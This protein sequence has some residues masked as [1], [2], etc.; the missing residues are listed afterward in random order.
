VVEV[1]RHFEFESFLNSLEPKVRTIVK[2][3][4]V[5]MFKT[6]QWHALCKKTSL[7]GM[8]AAG[9][10]QACTKGKPGL[11][12]DLEVQDNNKSTDDLNSYWLQ[13]LQTKLNLSESMNAVD[14]VYCPVFNTSAL[15]VRQARKQGDA[16]ATRAAQKK[17]RQEQ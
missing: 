13:V 12:S 8:L 5:Y 17:Q 7:A 6:S 2:D 3:R 1:L 14:L 9:R 16:A 15:L 11:G 10:H 4:A